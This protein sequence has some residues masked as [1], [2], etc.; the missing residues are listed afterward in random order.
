MVVANYTESSWKQNQYKSCILTTCQCLA[1]TFVQDKTH[2]QYSSFC[3]IH[4][5]VSKIYRNMDKIPAEKLY[6]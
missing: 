4:V 2:N 1:N 3:S 6:L 5:A